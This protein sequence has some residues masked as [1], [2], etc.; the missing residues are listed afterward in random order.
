MLTL[1]QPLGTYFCTPDLL[2]VH[3]EWLVLDGQAAAARTVLLNAIDVAREQGSRAAAL[4]AALALAP[5]SSYSR[6]DME[7]LS[8]LRACLPADTTTDDAR[9]ATAILGRA[10]ATTAS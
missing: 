10:A 7:L 2:R 8:G 5:T 4:R 6:P 3:A 9:E 1:S